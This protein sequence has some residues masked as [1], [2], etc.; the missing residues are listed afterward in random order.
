MRE[1]PF[2]V[3]SPHHQ[4]QDADPST[5]QN[6]EHLPNRYL[7]EFFFCFVLLSALFSFNL[8]MRNPFHIIYPVGHEL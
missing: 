6:F 7:T 3:S 2:R 1:M 4:A 5:M 8:K